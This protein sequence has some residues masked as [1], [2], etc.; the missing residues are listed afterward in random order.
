MSETL[1]AGPG[2]DIIAQPARRKGFLS[3]LLVGHFWKLFALVTL[4]CSVCM[5]LRAMAACESASLASLQL[6]AKPQWQRGAPFWRLQSAFPQ[7][8][9]GAEA[10]TG[11]VFDDNDGFVPLADSQVADET[12]YKV[13]PWENIL[14]IRVHVGKPSR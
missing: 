14:Y 12:Q 2:G 1:I 8:R 4:E 6:G 7:P 5:G 3:A 9:P 11:T 10:V 13:I